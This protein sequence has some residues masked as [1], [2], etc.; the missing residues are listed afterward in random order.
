MK[1]L[2]PFLGLAFSLFFLLAFSNPGFAGNGTSTGTAKGGEQRADIKRPEGAKTGQL[3][4][5]EVYF[6]IGGR[7]QKLNK[8]EY[9][10]TGKSSKLVSIRFSTPLEEG[11][12]IEVEIT[13]AERG[14]FGSF[15]MELE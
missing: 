11:D 3:D 4:V 2:N 10:V 5:E 8:S 6:L 14:R 7:R 12:V 1:T 15:P 9:T 13:T